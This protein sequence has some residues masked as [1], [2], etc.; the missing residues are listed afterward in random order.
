MKDL[1]EEFFDPNEWATASYAT[2]IF[3]STSDPNKLYVEKGCKNYNGVEI[4]T[5]SRERLA[6]SGGDRQRQ[7]NCQSIL[8]SIFNKV[9]SP[10]IITN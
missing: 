9:T 4:L 5:I 10:S 6:Y 2:I 1:D 3:E 7:K 8:I